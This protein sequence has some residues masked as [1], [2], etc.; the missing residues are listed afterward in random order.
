MPSYKGIKEKNLCVTSWFSK[1]NAFF[2]NN[3]ISNIVKVKWGRENYENIECNTD[4][5]PTLFKAQL[6]ALTGVSIE[7]QKVMC[8][9]IALKDDEWNMTVKDVCKTNNFYG[10]NIF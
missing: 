9:G 4:E 10:E 5:H 1:Q 2:F 6:Y 7:R 8:K 3:S